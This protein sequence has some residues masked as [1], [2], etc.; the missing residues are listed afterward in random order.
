[1][2]KSNPTIQEVLQWAS[3]FLTERG[4][5]LVDATWSARQLMSRMSGVPVNQLLLRMREESLVA[6]SALEPLLLRVAQ[7]EPV[8]YVTG[9]A[10]FYG[11]SFQVTPDTLIPRPETEELVELARTFLAAR[12]SGHVIE[13][14]VGTGCVVL[15]L[16]LECPQHHYLGTDI[17]QAALEVAEGNRQHYEVANVDWLLSDVWQAVP[18]RSYDAIISNPPYIAHSEVDVM[19][20]SVLDYEPH[21]ALFA[22]EDGLAIYRAIAAQLEAYLAPD[23]QAF[24]EIG[25]QQ[26]ARVQQL[27]QEACPERA[28]AVHADLSVQDR[29]VVVGPRG[30]AK[31]GPRDEAKMGFRDGA[32]VSSSEEAQGSSRGG[33]KVSSGEET[34][35]SSRGGAKVGHRDEAKMGSRGEAKVSS[36]EEAQGNSLGKTNVSPR[37]GASGS[38]GRA[39]DAGE[40]AG[41]G[42]E[43][44]ILWKKNGDE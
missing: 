30:E 8:Q 6:Q 16:A 11:R 24:F 39:T 36:G 4:M 43:A 22:A 1:M 7:G 41:P 15:S 42:Q 17:S 20:A 31:V 34:H 35:E 10:E 21:L 2:E 32:K 5:E 28:V 23:G 13:L 44:P 27:F 3:C 14:G 33:A 38:Q 9:E 18:E 26:G 12:A 25:Y 37:D 29:M 19:D 40:G